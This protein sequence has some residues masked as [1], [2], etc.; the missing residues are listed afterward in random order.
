[1]NLKFQKDQAM[2]KEVE[3]AIHYWGTPVVLISTLNEDESPNLAPMSSAW[4][5]GWSCMLGLDASSK[6]VENL[7]RRGECVLNLAS[8]E[9]AAAVDRLAKLT[10]SASVPLHKELL[11]YHYTADKFGAA[12]LTPAPSKD[13]APPRVME[14]PVQLEALVQNI[15]PFAVYDKR[16]AV[17]SCSVEIRIVRVHVEESLLA[18]NHPHRIDPNKWKPL[19]MSFRQFYGMG[20]QA[21]PSR[22]GSGPEDLYAPWKVKGLKR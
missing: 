19:L 6:T 9:N 1:M 16:M 15:R 20:N 3:P 18:D 11:G 4:W 14:C 12:A 22:L 8:I 13:V 10:G 21:H 2:H 17:P 5:L 7:K